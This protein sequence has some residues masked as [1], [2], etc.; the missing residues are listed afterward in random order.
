MMPHEIASLVVVSWK[1]AEF[2]YCSLQQR[3]VDMGWLPIV[4][5]LD[6]L[7]CGLRDVARNVGSYAGE[8]VNDLIWF[9]HQS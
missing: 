3:K 6:I 9:R 1:Q 4:R 5:C 7:T 2:C 8:W